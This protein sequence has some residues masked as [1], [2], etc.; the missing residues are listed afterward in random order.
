MKFI[1]SPI[2]LALLP[3]SLA[4]PDLALAQGSPIGLVSTIQIVRAGDDGEVIEKAAAVVP[5]DTLQ[6]TTDFINR[7][8]ETVTDFT[9]LNPVPDNVVLTSKS[10]E[11]IEVSIDGG[12]SWGEL[13]SLA[14]PTDDGARRPATAEDVTH[15]RWIIAR[16][17]PDGKGS[18]SY[19]ATVK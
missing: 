18:V 3:I 7:S 14:V 17:A 15:M 6:F 1:I 11:E 4:L 8:G 9:V 13:S 10:A 2:A 12:S 16:L 5:G 19:R